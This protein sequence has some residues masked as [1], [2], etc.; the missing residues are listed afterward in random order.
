MS[1]KVSGGEF[2]NCPYFAQSLV[3]LALTKEISFMDVH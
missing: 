1:D 3:F 2:M